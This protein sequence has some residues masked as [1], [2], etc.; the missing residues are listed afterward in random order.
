MVAFTK[1]IKRQRPGFR[2]LLKEG[3]KGSRMLWVSQQPPSAA[4]SDIEGLIMFLIEY[5]VESGLA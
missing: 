2:L 5:N 1:F 3:G 4:D